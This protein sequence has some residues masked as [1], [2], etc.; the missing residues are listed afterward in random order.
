M[1][2]PCWQPETP[3][4]LAKFDD[5]GHGSAE[6]RIGLPKEK[7]KQLFWLIR[8]G[9]LDRIEKDLAVPVKALNFQ[10]SDRRMIEMGCSQTVWAA[11]KEHQR[12]SLSAAGLKSLQTTVLRITAAAQQALYGKLSSCQ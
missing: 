2:W 3:N 7:R 10:D 6:E 8:V 5:L 1:Y 4:W 12:G 11:V 9:F